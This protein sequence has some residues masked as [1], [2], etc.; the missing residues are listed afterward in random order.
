MGLPWCSWRIPRRTF[1]NSP[2][3]LPV[4]QKAQGTSWRC[5]CEWP[6]G[7]CFVA[8]SLWRCWGAGPQSPQHHGQ[9]LNTNGVFGLHLSLF[10][11]HYCGARGNIKAK[12]IQLTEVFW[13]EVFTVIHDE[14]PSDIELDVILLFLVLKEVKRC[15]A[16]N[17]EQ[18]SEFKLALNWKV[19]EKAKICLA[20]MFYWL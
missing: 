10:S 7:S 19:L 8:A 4:Q 5:F 20:S 12:K 18:C 16:R 6:S 13:D 14:D 1:C 15:T 17:K 2:C 3:P 9:N 11:Q